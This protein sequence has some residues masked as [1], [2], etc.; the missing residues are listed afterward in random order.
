M[1]NNDSIEL[2]DIKKETLPSYLKET[3]AVIGKKSGTIISWKDCDELDRKTATSLFNNAE[4]EI[5]LLFR[6]FIADKGSIA[7]K[8]FEYNL[9]ENSYTLTS[10]KNVQINDPLFI[11]KN[12]LMSKYLW[13]ASEIQASSALADPAVYYKKYLTNCKKDSESKPTSALNANGTIKY[14]FE[15]K[16][17]K[18]DFLNRNSLK[19]L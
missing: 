15:W 9:E 18:Y 12:T 8:I 19:Y 3:G 16:G 4:D 2:P 5:G 13:Q 6:N 11:Q 14:S 17:K 1:I 7:L 10:D